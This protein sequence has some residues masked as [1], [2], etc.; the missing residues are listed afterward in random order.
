MLLAAGRTALANF[1]DEQIA[2]VL[3]ARPSRRL[4][5][6]LIDMDGQRR[7][8]QRRIDEFHGKVS[9]DPLEITIWRMKHSYVF[10]AMRM[11]GLW[12]WLETGFDRK[13]KSLGA[14]GRPSQESR[15][16]KRRGD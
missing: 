16:G 4:A 5:L 13:A 11:L 3:T 1:S 12:K 9:S 14:T 7:H 10:R 8:L 15:Q 6:A 2:S